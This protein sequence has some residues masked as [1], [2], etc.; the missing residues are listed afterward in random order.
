M[1]GEKDHPS[2][3]A[4][5]ILHRFFPRVRTTYAPTIIPS[6]KGETQSEIHNRTAYACAKIISDIDREWGETGTGPRAILLTSHAATIVAIGRVLIGSCPLSI[7]W[8][9]WR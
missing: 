3:A 2:P 1:R 7:M 4:P 8:R 6:T 5:E 9:R